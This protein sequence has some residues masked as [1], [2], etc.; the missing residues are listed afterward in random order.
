MSG[1]AANL[2]P[3]RFSAGYGDHGHS[4]LPGVEVIGTGCTDLTFN[5][6]DLFI[7]QLAES[8]CSVG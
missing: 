7:E 3:L 4:L 5:E 2:P 6:T 8:S 1:A